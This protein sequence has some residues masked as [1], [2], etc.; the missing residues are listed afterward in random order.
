LENP[1]NPSIKTHGFQRFLPAGLL[2]SPGG[3]RAWVF[4]RSIV[5]SRRLGYQAALDGL[6]INDDGL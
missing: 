5:R 4:G 3:L 1:I 2:A 6:L